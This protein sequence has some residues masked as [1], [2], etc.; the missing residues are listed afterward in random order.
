MNTHLQAIAAELGL[1]PGLTSPQKIGYIGYRHKDLFD[2]IVAITQLGGHTLQPLTVEELAHCNTNEFDVLIYTDISWRTGG[3]QAWRVTKEGG[4][5]A[6][7][8]TGDQKGADP[9][10]LGLEKNHL[11]HLAERAYLTGRLRKDSSK[12]FTRGQNLSV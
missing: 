6:W 2:L 8:Y 9:V 5:Q 3:E 11:L 7:R 1:T 12:W 4:I 10:Q